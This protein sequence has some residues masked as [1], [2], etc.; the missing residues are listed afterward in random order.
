MIKVCNKT[1]NELEFINEFNKSPNFDNPRNGTSTILVIQ[2]GH[3]LYLRKKTK[4]KIRIDLINDIYNYLK[5]HC[6]G[7]KIF[8]KDI[9]E[10]KKEIS[11]EFKDWH[12]CNATFIMMIFRFVLGKEIYNKSPCYLQL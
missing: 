3:I 6:I 5:E 8:T 12:D 11:P 4:I 1:Y 9:V 10:I 2:N 7:K